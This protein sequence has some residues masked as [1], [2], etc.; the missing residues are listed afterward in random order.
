MVE[1]RPEIVP[2][3]TEAAAPRAAA[4]R[5]GIELPT[6]RKNFTRNAADAGASR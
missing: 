1:F 5:P 3:C 4:H 2:F 6:S